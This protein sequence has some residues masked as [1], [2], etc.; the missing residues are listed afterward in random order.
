[1]LKAYV[2][3]PYRADSDFKVDMNIQRAKEVAARLWG[4]GY[5]V[6]C[7]HTNSAH[8]SGAA[9][10]ESFLKGN[11]EWLYQADIAVVL[12]NYIDSKGSVMEIAFCETYNIKLFFLG[13]DLPKTWT[14]IE[15]YVK[16]KG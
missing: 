10:E 3:G 14:E 5:A 11:L 4:L 16:D 6:F 8:F 13:F 7:P 1:M 9:P 12:A 15:K 2:I